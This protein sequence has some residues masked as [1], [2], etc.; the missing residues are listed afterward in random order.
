MT[1]L[2]E[3]AFG[4]KAFAAVIVRW[5]SSGVRKP[6]TLSVGQEKECIAARSSCSFVIGLSRN[7]DAMVPTA[8]PR[9]SSP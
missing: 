9:K 7:I 1:G 5:E 3:V 4:G 2:G 6:Q 8:V